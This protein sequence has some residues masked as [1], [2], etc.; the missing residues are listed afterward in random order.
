MKKDASKTKKSKEASALSLQRQ[1]DELK[2][3]YARLAADFAN[4]QKRVEQERLSLQKS[5][6]DQ[7]LVKLFPVFDSFYLAIRHNPLELLTQPKLTPADQERIRQFVE[8]VALVEKQME[9][10]LAQVGLSRVPTKGQPFDPALH[11]AV[12]YETCQTVPVDVI[13][14]EVEAGWWVDG[15]VI[16]PAKVRVSKGPEG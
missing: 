15:V 10:T 2:S 6:N 4:Y 1:L 8:G 13:I 12:T 3:N 11:E 9:E 5:A 7:L 14:D 16:K